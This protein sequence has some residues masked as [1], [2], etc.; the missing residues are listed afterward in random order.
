MF[1]H[2][3]QEDIEEFIKDSEELAETNSRDIAIIGIA[4]QIGGHPNLEEFW[5]D[6]VAGNTS[7]RELPEERK[8]DVEDA[9]CTLHQKDRTNISFVNGAYLQNID[10]FDFEFFKMTKL[11]ATVMDPR[12]R[13]LL[14]STIHAIEDAGYDPNNFKGSNTGV[15]IGN[16]LK[17]QDDYFDLIQKKDPSLNNL[18][19]PGNL[20]SILSSRISYTLDLKGPSYVID[21]A[22]SSSLAAIHL[23]KKAIQNH[24]CDMALV[25]AVNLNIVAPLKNLSG[26]GVDSK[27]GFT[28]TFDQESDG[29]GIGEGVITFLLKDYKLA[30][31]DHDHIYG[32]IKG[33]AVNQ[34]GKSVGITA[35]NADAQKSLLINAW[36]DANIHPRELRFI[37]AHGT[38][39]K[40]G[41]V[42]EIEALTS[43]FQQFTSDKQFCA[44]GTVK[45]NVGHTDS[46]SGLLGLFKAV[47]AINNHK[48]PKN[49]FFQSPNKELNFIQSPVYVADHDIDL[50]DH[51]KTIYGGISS[52][53]LSGTNVHVVIGEHKQIKEPVDAPNE[54]ILVYSAKNL[55]SL[56][57]LSKQHYAFLKECDEKDIIHYCYT[58]QIGRA[59]YDYRIAIIFNHKEEVLTLLN[60][61]IKNPNFKHKRVFSGKVS[62]LIS[63]RELLVERNQVETT[64]NIEIC[65]SYIQGAN[66]P[67]SALYESEHHLNRVKLPLYPF[68]RKRCWIEEKKREQDDQEFN[69]LVPS[70]LIKTIESDVYELGLN[71]H[72]QW[73]LGEHRVNEQFLLVGTAYTEIVSQIARKYYGI[74][75]VQIENFTLDKGLFAED[76]HDIPLQIN[77]KEFQ[78]KYEFYMMSQT[79]KGEKINHCS[80]SFTDHDQMDEPLV[81]V[82][83]LIHSLPNMKRITPEVYLFGKIQTSYRWQVTKEI[84][85]GQD[86]Y[87]SRIEAPKE[88]DSE[89]RDYQLYPALLD[90]ALNFANSM[91][92]DGVF[93]PW[94]YGNITYYSQLEARMYSYAEIQKT[95]VDRDIAK[96]NIMILS[97][98]GK[99]LV[100]VTDYVVKKVDLDQMMNKNKNELFTSQISWEVISDLQHDQENQLDLSRMLF[101]TNRNNSFIQKLMKSNKDLTNSIIIDLNGKNEQLSKNS[102]NYYSYVDGPNAND[103]N[104]ILTRHQH[105]F[106]H[107]IYLPD[108]DVYENKGFDKGMSERVHT[109]FFQLMKVISSFKRDNPLSVTILSNEAFP[110]LKEE[111]RANYFSGSL[112]GL[113]KSLKME[114][115]TNTFKFIDYDDSDF[116]TIWN[117]IHRKCHELVVGIRKEK[118]YKEVFANHPIRSHSSSVDTNIQSQGV[119]LVTGGLGGIGLTLAQ[120]IGEQAPA[121]I[122]LLGRTR[123]PVT[124]QHELIVH[125]DPKV[126]LALQAIRK[127]GAEVYYF[128]G[129]ISNEENMIDVMADIYQ[130]FDRIDGVIHASGIPSGEILTFKSVERFDEVLSAKVNGTLIL[131]HLLKKQ[132]LDFFVTCSSAAALF[133][134]IGQCDYAT[135]NEF[136]NLYCIDRSFKSPTK[137]VSIIWPTWKET[138]MAYRAGFKEESSLIQPITNQEGARYFSYALQQDQPVVIVGK[139]NS[140][141]WEQERIP[142]AFQRNHPKSLPV[143]QHSNS[144]TKDE[145]GNVEDYSLKQIESQLLKLWIRV[146]GIENLTIEEKFFEI[147]GDS[148]LATYLLNEI[149]DQ[150]GNMVDITDIFSYSSVELMAKKI[151]QEI[152]KK[153]NTT[154]ETRSSE[155]KSDDELDHLLSDLSQGNLSIEDVLNKI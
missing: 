130:Q 34:D 136:L 6:L 140:V 92:A 135:A 17:N 18:A 148:I 60:E 131:E 13:L 152:Q 124:N 68:K 19:I 105:D 15:Y 76:E 71:I 61:T 21:T 51:E 133:G 20:N 22:C 31:A 113:I 25:G 40:L 14:E 4:G 16:S 26:L 95:S 33:S 89:I 59:H 43:S 53:G 58:S 39:T 137:Y 90:A 86:Q 150:F 41:D 72:R 93:L 52:F 64:N 82:N 77:V 117:E 83:E 125:E 57:E 3:I 56:M 48:Y 30:L 78:G 103:L 23:A 70:L 108:E 65:K 104:A 155:V 54:K 146:L 114:L 126:N 147:N 107:L 91:I 112:R 110:I 129:D 120:Y 44:I 116:E 88:L 143:K 7:I 97:E 29:T 101:V 139:V 115:P 10:E 134:S 128:A 99:V 45:T 98:T 87:L 42:V 63:N 55:D 79:S 46:V 94:K 100:K 84:F 8:Q 154:K 50:R 1:N 151:Y 11:E 27:D 119:Y 80:G 85:S 96:L 49:L 142:Y 81:D 9:Y 153:K 69:Q 122:I 132:S 145:V 73:E 62:S 138:G 141:L 28:R 66:I 32:V 149:N 2:P 37:E 102:R 121:K 67:W 38:A 118:L 144:S 123:Y 106:N 47:Y 111:K 127:Q 35:P 12:Q 36:R 5:N 74:Q 109:H 75:K 24:E